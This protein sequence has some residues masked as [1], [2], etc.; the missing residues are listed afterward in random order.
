M[1]LFNWGEKNRNLGL[2][3]V[4]FLTFLAFSFTNLFEGEL[5]AQERGIEAGSLKLEGRAQP[6]VVSSNIQH[7]TSN[8]PLNISIPSKWGD[9]LQS[10]QGQDQKMIIHIQDVH[11]HFEAQ[12]NSAKMMNE[13]FQEHGAHGLKMIGLEGAQGDV[14]T[15]FFTAFPDPTLRKMMAGY[16]MKQGKIS[17]AE[18]LSIVKDKPLPLIG[19]ENMAHYFEHVVG[20][21]QG[22]DV[23]EKALPILDR[24][25]KVILHLREKVY[26]KEVKEF[27]DQATRYEKGEMELG[28]YIEQLKVQSSKLK[29]KDKNSSSSSNIQLSTSNILSSSIYPNINLMLQ[30]KKLE[31]RIDLKQVEK[32]RVKL[33]EDLSCKLV[34]EEGV[35]LMAKSLYYRLEKIE[36]WEYYEYLKKLIEK[37]STSYIVHRTSN[38]KDRTSDIELR[39]ADVEVRSTKSDALNS[40]Y[41]NLMQYIQMTELYH[42]I[43]SD[44]LL[45]ECEALRDSLQNE[46]MKTPEEKDLKR[47][48]EDFTILKNFFLMELKK[49]ELRYFTENKKGVSAKEIVEGLKKIQGPRSWVQGQDNSPRSPLILRGEEKQKMAE[50]SPLS[51][52]QG[53]TSLRGDGGV[54]NNDIAFL[55]SHL[56]DLEQFYRYADV[57]EKD[58]VENTLAKMEEEKSPIAILYAG[59]FHTEGLTKRLE[60]KGLSYV[61]V[62]PRMTHFKLKTPYVSI[63]KD[64]QTPLEK[65]IKQVGQKEK[66]TLAV[67][68]MN[69]GP[70]PIDAV[71]SGQVPASPAA[72]VEA[73]GDRGSLQTLREKTQVILSVLGVLKLWQQV[74]WNRDWPL[75]NAQGQLLW[76]WL[77]KYQELIQYRVKNVLEAQSSNGVEHQVEVHETYRSEERVFMSIF[78]DGH[79][80]VGLILRVSVA[81]KMLGEKKVQDIEEYFVD[82]ETYE[83]ELTLAQAQGGLDQSPQELLRLIRVMTGGVGRSLEEDL[84]QVRQPLNQTPRLR[85]VRAKVHRKERLNLYEVMRYRHSRFFDIWRELGLEGEFRVMFPG[86]EGE[87]DFWRSDQSLL[88]VYRRLSKSPLRELTLE[89][90]QHAL[91]QQAEL[92]DQKLKGLRDFLVHSLESGQWDK[93]RLKRMAEEL[94]RMEDEMRQFSVRVGLGGGSLKDAEDLFLADLAQR[95]RADRVWMAYTFGMGTVK[96][97]RR[98]G[99]ELED[100]L[101]FSISRGLGLEDRIA[102]FVKKNVQVQYS[103]E[104]VPHR[105][106]LEIVVARSPEAERKEGSLEGH[107]RGEDLSDFWK[108][109]SGQNAIVAGFPYLMEHAYYDFGLLVYRLWHNGGVQDFGKRIAP[110]LGEW[111]ESFE[112]ESPVRVNE[113]AFFR[114][115][116]ERALAKLEAYL[117]M[118]RIGEHYEPRNIQPLMKV[119]V[120]SCAREA[121]E[122]EIELIA[123]IPDEPLWVAECD[124]NVFITSMLDLIQNAIKYS[125]GFQSRRKGKKVFVRLKR[126]DKNV[127]IEVE[128]EGI[129]I[130]EADRVKIFE[131]GHR[132]SNTQGIDGTGVGLAVLK[133]MVDVMGGE[134]SVH[135]VEGEGTKFILFFPEVDRLQEHPSLSTREI[136][137][138]TGEAVQALATSLHPPRVSEEK[139]G[140]GPIVMRGLP[141]GSRPV[142]KRRFRIRKPLAEMEGSFRTEAA[143]LTLSLVMIWV[144]KIPYGFELFLA[145]IVFSVSPQSAIAAAFFISGVL[146]ALGAPHFIFWLVGLIA[147]GEVGVLLK[148]YRISS[149]V[150]NWRAVSIGMSSKT[151]NVSKSLSPV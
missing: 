116:M 83:K 10:H 97:Y 17:G 124:E 70:Q 145:L 53:A 87:R 29:E 98:Y 40:K 126:V 49:G 129:G 21:K 134:V 57:R 2:R 56:K 111:L 22:M 72:R 47:I 85:Q 115:G 58:L 71:L 4:S 101:R 34:K 32:E 43:N 20:W 127:V 89:E 94:K 102:S 68:P 138:R 88:Q 64:E 67:E 105:D 99:F 31:N 19:V 11:C 24:I 54:T 125:Y 51:L 121:R 146:V 140:D 131:M 41:A 18:Y 13:L 82:Q 113:A 123:E 80:T 133:A 63:M 50:N 28:E 148:S 52:P 77:T 114:E 74:E 6:V 106:I 25:E 73:A 91:H 38:L 33:L 39:T 61:V 48:E 5:L 120:E 117:E 36:A 69:S 14:D 62:A 92:Y 119:V 9:I 16:L 93:A 137:Q 79:P 86:R 12:S 90:A 37:D 44:E 42:Q 110:R 60:E 109:Y 112:G 135:S 136:E 141:K 26:S 45:K 95:F 100:L 65:M 15:S 84:E 3:L 7:P 142:E 76:E 122:S 132:A 128:D 118:M 78:V 144:F 143:L 139:V 55:D 23:K 8:N 149:Q 151:F 66:S 30:M 103:L 75:V 59:G 130:P 35:E 104:G 96:Y 150:R 147:L 1:S 108:G 27:L 107:V 46:I 81:E